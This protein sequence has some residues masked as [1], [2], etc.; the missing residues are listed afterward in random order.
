MFSLIRQSWNSWQ[1]D[2]GLAFLAVVALAT[3]IG[4]ATAIFTVVNAVLLKPLPYS[5]GERW[6]ALFAGSTDDPSDL[7]H[8]S[9]LTIA[10]LLAYEQQT[11]SFDVFGWFSIGG[12]FNLT[13]PGQPRHLEGIEVSPALIT[14]TG[15]NP[16]AGRFFSSSDGPDAALISHRLFEQLGSGIIGHPITLNGRSYTVVGAMPG[17][18]RFPLVTVYGRDTGNDV[19]LPMQRPRSESQLRDYGAYAAYA[20]LKPGISVEQARADAKRAAEQIRKQNHPFDPTY[21]AALFGIRETVVR[22]IRPIL[23]VLIGAAGLLLLVTCANV[24]GLLVSRSV[25]RARE[26]AVR[27][28]LGGGH[29]Q[30]ALQYFFESL[31][32]SVP[33]VVAGIAASVVLIRLVVSFAA[34]YIPRSDEISTNWQVVLFALAL[35]FVTA[36]L[37]AMAPLGQ[38][39]RM[40]PN[41]VLSDGVRASAGIRSRKLSQALVVA[42]VALAFTLTSAAA[43]LVWQLDRLKTTSPG[44]DPS[45]V[46]TFE[47]TTSLERPGEAPAGGAAGLN[48]TP[49][50]AAVLSAYSDRLLDALQATAGVTSTALANQV[51][52]NGCCMSAYVLPERRSDDRE[53]RKMVS[54]MGVSPSYFKTLRIPLLAGRLLNA[55]DTDEKIVTVV[56]DQ[57][58]AKRYW[59]DQNAVGQFGR[60]SGPKGTRFQVAG[61]VGTV[62]NKGLG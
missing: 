60:F 53:P 17:W 28:A 34:E 50:T 14:N 31:F 12:D 33:A 20:K 51:P 7:N 35:A 55:H 2:K 30:L 13:S 52:L 38:A 21:T 27:V 22:P 49:D 44:F 47:I 6:V 59:H 56:I 58:A 46:M 36:T 37:S 48:P 19:W 10:D 5:Q 25:G 57:D 4:C 16:V 54:I 3:G 43:I 11:S 23:L 41:E 8:V 24:A 61:V 62:R 15:A 45:G 9:A 29:K 32:L 26:T 18:F 40:Q 1:R 42:E 39:L